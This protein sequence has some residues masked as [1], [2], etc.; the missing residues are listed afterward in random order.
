MPSKISLNVQIETGAKDQ[1]KPLI[2]IYQN[3]YF[4]EE[5]EK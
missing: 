5:S 1:V 3:M 2:S 4:E